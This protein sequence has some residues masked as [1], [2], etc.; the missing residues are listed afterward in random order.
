VKALVTGGG[1]FLGGRIIDMLLERGIAVRSF[2]RGG[3]PQLK[4]RGVEV[5]QGDVGDAEAVARAIEGCDVIFHVAAKAGAWGPYEDFHLANVTGTEH[6]VAG[7]K[8][9]GVK[10]LVYTS[11]PSVIFNG[12]DMEGVDESIPYPH[13]HEAFY[14]RTKAMA[15]QYV[16]H[17]NGPDLA[18]VALRPH[19]I[20]GPGD[21]NLTPRIVSRAKAG[22]LR[23]F[24]GPAKTI[25]GTYIDNAAHAH[26][27]AMD[28]LEPGSAIAGKAYFIANGERVPVWEMVNH[29]VTAAGLPPVTREVPPQAAYAIGAL[30][31]GVHG[32]FNLPGEPIMTRWVA[33]EL[34]TSHWFDLS[35]AKRDLGYEPVVTLEEGIRRLR[36][37][38]STGR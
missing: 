8:R 27:L 34:A 5:F 26:L 15:E 22:R 36:E 13:E 35:A 14:P 4:A 37:S 7:C 38:F 28:R 29:I 24:S 2:A 25:D 12:Q 16:L 33:E 3:Y 31:E 23:R 21:T 18:T 32:L 1:G 10:K 19:L 11:S 6:V 9:H 30:L 17:S 20:W